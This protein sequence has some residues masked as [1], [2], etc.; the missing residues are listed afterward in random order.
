MCRTKIVCL[1]LLFALL[2]TVCCQ[3]GYSAD[4][5]LTLDDLP[6]VGKSLVVTSDSVL[7]INDDES[8]VIDDALL[9]INGTDDAVTTFRIVNNGVLTIKSTRIGCNHANFTIQN[10]GTLNFQT[11]HFTVIG[12]STLSLGNEDSCTMTD[13]SV[14]VY[15]GYATFT[16]T[17]TMTI[18]NGYFKDQFDGTTMTNHGVATLYTTVFVANGAKGRFDIGNTGDMELHQC[19]FDVNYGAMV[20][21]NTAGSLLMNSS[22]IDVSGS[23]HGQRS[24]V[25]V[26]VGPVGASAVWESCT[27]TTNNGVINYQ[28]LRNSRFTDCQ[29]TASFDGAI[30]LATHGPFTFDGSCLGGTGSVNVANFDSMTLI[31]SFYNSSNYFTVYNAGEINAENWLVKTLHQDAEVFLTNEG[32]LTFAPSFIEDV[33]SSAI[34]SVGPEGQEFVESSGGTITVTNSG[35][36]SGKSSTDS[37]SDSTLIYILAI[38]ATAIIVIVVFFIAKKKK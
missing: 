32:N 20:N 7:T 34:I 23:S 35:S 21:L 14:D 29:L 36:F 28:N 2:V 1:T 24:G 13:T 31:D 3:V 27:L 12:N 4:T 22:N 10:M 19:T 25:N 37:G 8:A 18:H 38:A 11:T 17:G 30:N 16:S 9:Q 15:G 33:S 5:V 26:A 6:G